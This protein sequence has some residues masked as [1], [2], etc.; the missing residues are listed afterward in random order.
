MVTLLLSRTEA[1]GRIR[2]DQRALAVM[3]RSLVT[4]SSHKDSSFK[5]RMVRLISE[6]WLIS[7]FPA[8]L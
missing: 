7:V 5:I 6:C 8:I 1:A 2:S 4:I 3:K